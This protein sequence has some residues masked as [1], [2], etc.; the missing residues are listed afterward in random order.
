MA[1]DFEQLSILWTKFITGMWATHTLDSCFFFL[2]VLLS[3]CNNL[4]YR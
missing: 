2:I 3:I 1:S 4:Q